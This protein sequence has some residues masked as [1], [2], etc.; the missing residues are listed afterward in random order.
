MRSRF[1]VLALATV[2]LLLPSL[3]PRAGTSAAH[4]SAARATYSCKNPLKAAWIYVGNTS[5]AGWTKAHDNG[6]LAVVHKFGCKVKTTYKENIPEGPGVAQTIE[7]LVHDGNKIIFA[8]SFG[9]QPA[10][11]Q[12]AKKHPNVYF[13]MST[14][15][16]VLKNMAE[17]FGAV[18][19]G[20]YLGCLAGAY[21]SKNGHLGF[22]APFAIP[23]IIREINACEIAIKQVKKNGKLQVIWTNTWFDP[24]KERQAAQSLVASGNDVLVQS[25]DSPATGEVA[26]S[27]HVKWV[28]YQL[29]ES[30]FGPQAWL[31]GGL[32]NWGPYYVK[33]VG[34]VL[35]GKWKT[36][37]YY[38]SYRDG[39]MTLAKYGPGVTAKARSA[40]SA[41]LNALKSGKYNEFAGPLRD[42]HGKLRV[43][44]GKKATLKDR[45]TMNWFVQGVVGNPNGSG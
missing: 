6:R 45:L 17:Y 43:A 42:Q 35:Q 23:E 19:D 14:G 27:R 13:E 26:Q 15:S 3:V 1:P 25:E 44:K 4:A 34:E 22:V 37:F 16:T 20:F 10:V 41:K 18:E 33:K 32:I 7:D 30:K 21:A 36:N 29:D 31:T 24:A 5:D 8:T 12:E 28:G 39:F 2:A 40:V 9:Y 38:G 11:I